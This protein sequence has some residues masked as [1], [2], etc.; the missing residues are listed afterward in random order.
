MKKL[1]IEER[2][3]KVS[4]SSTGELSFP[5][6]LQMTLTATLQF[7]KHITPP[8]ND[9]AKGLIYDDMNHAFSKVLD[10]Y[11]PELELRPDITA[12]AILKMEN[13]LVEEKYANLKKESRK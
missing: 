7:A 2:N 3:G 12:E 11:D 13:Q 9:T 1:T 4:M 10:L 6:F 5:E 8:N